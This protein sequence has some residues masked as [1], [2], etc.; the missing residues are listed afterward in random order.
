MKLDGFF[1]V[2][3]CFSFLLFVSLDPVQNTKG[4]HMDISN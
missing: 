1:V 3:F 2:C 4:I